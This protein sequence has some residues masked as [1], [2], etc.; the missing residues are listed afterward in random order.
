LTQYG[1]SRKPEAGGAR[2]KHDIKN[3]AEIIRSASCSHRE[4][5]WWP[6]SQ[7]KVETPDEVDVIE[8]RGEHAVGER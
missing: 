2:E 3:M 4:L 8:H 5:K 1:F 6:P 7:I